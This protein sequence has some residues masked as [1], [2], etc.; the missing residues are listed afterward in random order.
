MKTNLIFAACMLI[1]ITAFSQ[2]LTSKVYTNVEVVAPKFNS[3]L[4]ESIN[5]F[6][7]NAVEFPSQ[8]K[9]MGLQ[10]TEVVE[11]KVTTEGNIMDFKIVN[12]ISAEID[13]E[14]IRVLKVTDGKWKPGLVNG[15]PVDMK[16]EVSVAFI[17]SSE[18]ELVKEAKELQERGNH[19]M[20]EKNN[21]EK[22][23]KYYNQ[24]IRLLPFEESLL[25][26]RGLCKYEL[27]DTEGA[28]ADWERIKNINDKN[29]SETNFNLA[30]NYTKLSGYKK[31]LTTLE[32]R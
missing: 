24:G 31:M 29:M 9:N 17:S 28:L 14:V 11:F 13:N 4:Y 10:G 19:W 30:G 1:A 25:A 7:K 21:P 26:A 15:A 12:S 20:F 5:D 3:S 27:G 22:A 23:I 18:K 16:K 6:L 2:N 8:A 32:N